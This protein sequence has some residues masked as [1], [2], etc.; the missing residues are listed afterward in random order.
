M[1]DRVDFSR[2]HVRR[3]RNEPAAE[4]ALVQA[5][6]GDRPGF[7]VDVGA[8]DPVLDSQSWH[9]EQRG[10]TGLL[11]EPDPDCAQRLREQRTGTVI[12]RA[13][14]SAANA[15]Q[16]LLLHRAG[17]HSTVEAQPIARGTAIPR[18]SVAVRCDTLDHILAEHGVRPG[19]DLLSVDIE[20]HELVAL[21][22]FDFARWQ[23]R[24]VLLEDHVI[25]L[26]KHRLMQSQGY[27]LVL[28]TGLNSW[29]MPQSQAFSHSLAA[30]LEFLRKYFLG[31]PL[32]KLRY[33]R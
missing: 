26:A 17:P 3:F 15:G 32:R 28:R 21:S 25:H 9:L 10:W 27:R 14:S 30:R 13:C 2:R 24:L 22:G 31:L 4:Q 23:P 7:Y 11:V 8:N 29:Y 18:E 20:G 12:E 6:F 33:A 16:M 5:F 1:E 19:F